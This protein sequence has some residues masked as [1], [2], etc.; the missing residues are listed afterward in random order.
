M[1]TDREK[2][3]AMLARGSEMDAGVLR[4]ISSG[5]LVRQS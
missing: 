1:A 5:H 2:P 3:L 4:E